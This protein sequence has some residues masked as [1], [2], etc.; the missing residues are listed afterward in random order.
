MRTDAHGVGAQCG[1]FTLTRKLQE[2]S[3]STDVFQDLAHTTSQVCWSSCH[4][5]KLY[6]LGDSGRMVLQLP[7]WLAVSC[8][9][10][11]DVCG[12]VMSTVSYVS[13]VL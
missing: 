10:W 3:T 8:F 13:F 1:E 5:H 9:G 6:P 4:S 7:L 2:A 12:L 11:T